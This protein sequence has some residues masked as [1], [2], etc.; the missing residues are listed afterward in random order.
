MKIL[1][2]L[3]IFWLWISWTF[4]DWTLDNQTEEFQS[5]YLITQ[6]TNEPT[7]EWYQAWDIITFFWI[8][9][10]TLEDMDAYC[11]PN[12]VIEDPESSI[13]LAWQ[14]WTIADGWLDVFSALMGSTFGQILIFVFWILLLILIV[15]AIF[16]IYNLVSRK[17]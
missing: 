8:D 1:L 17:K 4:A 13:I 6:C 15:G 10:T 9:I 11:W 5:Y 7:W 3:S 12:P 2:W 16:F 14:M